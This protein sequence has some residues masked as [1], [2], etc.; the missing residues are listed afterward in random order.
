[1][2]RIAVFALSVVWALAGC[3]A[4]AIEGAPEA[5]AT[6]RAAAAGEAGV[7]PRS[8]RSIYALSMSMTDQDGRTVGLDVFRGQ[9]V[10]LGMFYGSC[11]TACPLLISTIRRAMTELDA[12]TDAE[13]RVLLVSFDPERDSPQALRAIVAQRGLDARWKLSSAPDDQARELAALLGIQYRKLPDGS[14]NHTSSI[15]LL[16][17]TGAIDT[18]LD[19]TTQP[20]EP[21][22]ARARALAGAK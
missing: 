20:V 4:T 13:I 2:S 10:F 3:R 14:F 21:L 18:R 9:P 11:P 22:V 1:M 7:R 17:R 8:D 16:D 19:D 15:V 6:A 12:S 5:S